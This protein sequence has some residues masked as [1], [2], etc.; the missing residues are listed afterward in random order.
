MISELM[1][2]VRRDDVLCIPVKPET[3]RIPG[4]DTYINRH[5]GSDIS[6]LKECV[7]DY[8]NEQIKKSG[9]I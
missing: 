4:M 9:F 7:I 5:P 3:V 2:H 1:I 6:K 8:I